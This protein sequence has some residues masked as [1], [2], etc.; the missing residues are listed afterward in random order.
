MH[1]SGKARVE[2]GKKLKKPSL[3]MG[4]KSVKKKTPQK[5]KPK[6]HPK[7]K[8]T[9]EAKPAYVK[10]AEKTMTG[11]RSDMPLVMPKKG[12]KS[13]DEGMI[14]DPQKMTK[15]RRKMLESQKWA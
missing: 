8:K 4:I 6:A 9:K 10:I 14:H 13:K 1:S 7:K 5:S 3:K 15:K 2:K 11:P 12:A